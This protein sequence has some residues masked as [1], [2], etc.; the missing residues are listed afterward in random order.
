MSETSDNISPSD[1]SDESSWLHDA[2]TQIGYRF[3][4]L[5]YLEAALTHR[6][7][8]S[9]SGGINYERLEF[10][11]DALLELAASE[12]LLSRFPEINEGDLT[13][14]RAR[15][16]SREHLASLSRQLDLGRFLRLGNGEEKSGGRQ[17][18]AILADVFESVSGAIYL[19][20]GLDPA[21]NFLL[22]HLNPDLDRLERGEI[23]WKDH[24]SQLQEALHSQGKPAPAY[25]VVQES[26]PAHQKSFQVE[27]RIGNKTV[28]TASGPSKK[29][30]EQLAAAGALVKLSQ[31]SEET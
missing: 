15:L 7:W 23:E 19:D 17:K 21:R 24:K 12:Q 26:G 9:S 18:K 1:W 5:S 28:G 25:R 14:M 6:S 20:G 11:G 27:V 3:R 8:D 13:R 22:E 4:N 31:D 16:V 29:K 2:Q 10:L 30:A